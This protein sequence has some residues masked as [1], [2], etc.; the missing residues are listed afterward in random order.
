MA[1]EHGRVVGAD[2]L[3][4]LCAATYR[5]NNLFYVTDTLKSLSLSSGY[6]YDQGPAGTVDYLRKPER[7]SS[8][9][10]IYCFMHASNADDFYVLLYKSK[11]SNYFAFSLNSPCLA[12]YFVNIWRKRFN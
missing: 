12:L 2:Q 1:L 6:F 7:T 10:P 9:G 5:F 4:P 8:S 3:R 11:Q